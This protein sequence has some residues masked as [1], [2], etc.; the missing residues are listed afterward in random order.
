MSQA[1]D[2]KVHKKMWMNLLVYLTVTDVNNLKKEL[3]RVKNL[4]NVFS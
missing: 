4:G 3:S 1:I 2:I